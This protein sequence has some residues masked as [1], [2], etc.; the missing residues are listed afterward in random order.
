MRL[1]FGPALD[2]GRR[3]GAAGGG[4]LAGGRVGQRA[5]EFVTLQRG[6]LLLLVGDLALGSAT[7][8]RHFSFRFCRNL[9]ERGTGVGSGCG[10]RL[11]GLGT[12][13]AL[14]TIILLA[15]GLM[16][17]AQRLRF[18]AQAGEPEKVRQ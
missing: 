14:P 17:F 15:F 8:R 5:L 1:A 3:A 13:V 7:A 18:R 9:G 12:R 10:G 16:L 6:L 2:S 11:V 4:V